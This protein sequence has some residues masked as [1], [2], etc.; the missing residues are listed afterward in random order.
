MY[1]NIQEEL[2]KQIANHESIKQDLGDAIIEAFFSYT[3]KDFDDDSDSM[4]DKGKNEVEEK[5]RKV[6]LFNYDYLREVLLEKH[7]G[8]LHEQK[9]CILPEE[10]RDL[11]P[12]SKSRQI[13]N[14]IPG[15]GDRKSSSC[16][17]QSNNAN[18]QDQDDMYRSISF[19]EPN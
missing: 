8:N 7:I 13:P 16:R 4:S 3:V 6:S 10:I 9:F 11:S 12:E 15:L 17:T 14:E 5:C 19:N 2:K 1:Q 18:N